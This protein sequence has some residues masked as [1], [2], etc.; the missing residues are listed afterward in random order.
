M[1]ISFGEM[2]LA[3]RDRSAWGQ[4]PPGQ[5]RWQDRE[6]R[7]RGRSRFTADASRHAPG[8]GQEAGPQDGAG[9]AEAE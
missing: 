1:A 3:A 2:R 6:R 5:R 7:K 8:S 9:E 4:R